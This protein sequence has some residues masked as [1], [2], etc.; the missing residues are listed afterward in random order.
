MKNIL[1]ATAVFSLAASLGAQTFIAGFDFTNTSGTADVG[2]YAADVAGSQA[3]VS[4][5]ASAF[6]QSSSAVP[7]PNA[8][9]T[10]E[11]RQ[12]GFDTVGNAPA[13][14]D[15]DGQNG[16]SSDPFGLFFQGAIDGLSFSIDIDTSGFNSILFAY[17]SFSDD[18][19]VQTGGEWFTSFDGAGDVSLDTVLFGASYTD[20]VFN[21][22][23][24]GVDSL[25]LTFAFDSL[26]ADTFGTDVTGQRVHFDNFAIGGT[27]VPEPSAYTAILGLVAIGFVAQR[28]RRK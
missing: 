19:A 12:V 18:N 28:R 4:L 22:D 10:L 9:V 17:D 23:V 7:F 25:T 2:V 13:L 11:T 16:F 5:N 1:I 26:E 21:I 20:E 14:S 24:T 3:G 6:I 15:F 27:P 8:G